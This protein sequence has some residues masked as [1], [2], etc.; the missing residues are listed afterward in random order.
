MK[1]VSNHCINEYKCP[2][3]ETQE[4]VRGCHFN[5]F[6]ND[7]SYWFPN[8]DAFQ[9]DLCTP[10][11]KNFNSAGLGNAHAEAGSSCS[12]SAKGK[13]ALE[14]WWIWMLSLKGRGLNI[15]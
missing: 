1:S 7:L 4:L 3:G 8:K 11:S 15:N 14:M 5:S 2:F 13:R 12:S 10:S 9:I 6:D